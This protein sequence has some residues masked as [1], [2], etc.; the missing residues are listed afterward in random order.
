MTPAR[1]PEARQTVPEQ[2]A[3][4]VAAVV[5]FLVSQPE[6]LLRQWHWKSA[7]LSAASRGSLFFAANVHRGL[8]AALAALLTEC[9]LRSITAGLFGAATQAFRRAQPSWAATLCVS[10]AL[11]ALSHTVEF[12]VHW[13]RHTPALLVSVSASVIFTVVTTQLSLFAMRRNAFIVGA[14]SR[15]LADDLR[16]LPSLFGGLIHTGRRHVLHG[17]RLPRGVHVNRAA[18]GAVIGN[19]VSG[20][21]EWNDD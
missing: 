20:G 14:G 2:P 5:G 17:C 12:V 21:L 19:E 8:D 18:R 9:V 16:R 6:W 11:P 1:P 13:A 10:L 15:S 7:V 4:R 3:P